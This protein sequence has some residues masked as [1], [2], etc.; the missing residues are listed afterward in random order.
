M[1]RRTARG[2]RLGLGLVGLTLLIPAT[3][4]LLRG[5]GQLA[6]MPA[7]D[8]VLPASLR[9]YAKNVWWFWPAVA[10]GA[11]VVALLAL[12]WLL[13][14]VR[15]DRLSTLTLEADQR[16]ATYVDARALSSAIADEVASLPGVRHARATVANSGKGAELHLTVIA[17]EDTDVDHLRAGA[18]TSVID[19]RRALE[20][21]AMPAVT[22]LRLRRGRRAARVT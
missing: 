1:S 9:D 4:I 8:P 6:G 19:A 22:D 15:T 21:L 13:V 11:V 20:G 2:K 16:G 7:N 18:L 14:Q 12:R 17:D 10:A 3:Y 5:T